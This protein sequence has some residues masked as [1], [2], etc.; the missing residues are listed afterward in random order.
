MYL[1]SLVRCVPGVG[2]Y[3]SSLHTLKSYWIKHTGN[4]SV[5][6]YEAGLIGVAARS[7]SGVI[8]IPVTILKTRF[9]VGLSIE[10]FRLLKRSYAFNIFVNFRVECID[11]KAWQKLFN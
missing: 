10:F 2:L 11:I 8:L 5:G 7:V 6:P 3:F 1:Q 4:S 9:E